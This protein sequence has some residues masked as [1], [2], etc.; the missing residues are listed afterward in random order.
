MVYW[1]DKSEIDVT[2]DTSDKRE[3]K[4]HEERHVE[5]TKEHWE[6]ARQEINWL[7]KKWCH[8]CD[9][10][11]ISFGSA[12]LR[13]WQQIAMIRNS[14]FDVSAYTED[15]EL[16]QKD[17][18]EALAKLAERKGALPAIE[19]AYRAAVAAFK[20]AGCFKK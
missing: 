18:N 13:Y 2:Y 9:D 16:T 20:A 19:T 8:P 12:S 11:A 6:Y 5:I 7:E 3:T 14:E 4:V 17:V 15:P 10:L 1:I